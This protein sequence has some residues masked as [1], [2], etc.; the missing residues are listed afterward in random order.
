MTMSVPV[1]F[2]EQKLW[3][4]QETTMFNTAYHQAITASQLKNKQTQ[5]DWEE[6]DIRTNPLTQATNST[7]NQSVGAKLG[8]QRAFDPG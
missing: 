3:C 7:S 4:L 8:G 5:T 1:L 2:H 6:Q